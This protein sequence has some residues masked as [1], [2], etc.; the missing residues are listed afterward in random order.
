MVLFLLLQIRCVSEDE[1]HN[2]TTTTN[3]STNRLFIKDLVGGANYR[4]QIAA[5]TKQ[6]VGIWSEVYDF[7]E[8]LLV[9]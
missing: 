5:A 2:C 6:G 7:G 3:G 9:S 4:I 8:F 1:S